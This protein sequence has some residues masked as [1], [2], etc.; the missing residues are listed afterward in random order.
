MS[1]PRQM[2]AVLQDP[3]SLPGLRKVTVSP[4]RE[5]TDA[6]AE[7]LMEIGS[8]TVGLRVRLPMGFPFVLPKVVI[9]NLNDVPRHPHVSGWDGD[10][11]YIRSSGVMVDQTDPVGLVA[12]AVAEAQRTLAECWLDPAVAQREWRREFNAL[13]TQACGLPS[14]LSFMNVDDVMRHVWFGM[15]VVTSPR[16]GPGAR[17]DAFPAR[18]VRREQA[19]QAREG[20]FKRRRRKRQKTSAR[21]QV[22]WVADEPRPGLPLVQ[23]GVKVCRGLYVP[24]PEAPIPPLPRMPSWD[25]SYGSGWNGE[26]VRGGIREMLGPGGREQLDALLGNR[27]STTAVFLSTPRVRDGRTLVG[28]MYHGLKGEH[29]LAAPAQGTSRRL[30]DPELFTLNRVDRGTL[31]ARGGTH[32][33]LAARRVLLIGCGSIGGHIAQMLASAGI[34]NLTLMD[35]DRLAW[36]NTFRHTLGMRGLHHMKA[37][38]LAEDLRDRMPY[39][40]VTPITQR[41]PL[42]P[43]GGPAISGF[44]L[45]IDATGEPTVSMSIA[46]RPTLFGGTPLIHTWLEP[47]GLGGHAMV[48]LPGQGCFTCLLGRDDPTEPLSFGP[49]F[50]QLGQDFQ[51][52]ELGCGAYYAPFS[53]L[54]ARRTAEL[55]TRL[56]LDVVLGRTNGAVLRSWK[57]DA[58]S[59]RAHGYKT[60]AWYDGVTADVLAGGI[61]YRSSHCPQCGDQA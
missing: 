32:L 23:K 18:D 7:G 37:E 30:P 42:A 43:D 2:V 8:F 40:K 52:D 61:P 55:A 13:W 19:R 26:G 57:G 39:L 58:A 45:V 53:D 50:A 17:G 54:D 41:L 11:C 1:Q 48:S 35:H 14:A 29:P 36:E 59:F 9:T 27:G 28:L 24:L 22:V 4:P 34:G 20:M 49:A 44:D 12:F 31:Q 51:L 5:G 46:A 21:W 3:R 56:S 16:P 25:E 60:A 38:A 6:L 33:D 10:V 47:L 15:K